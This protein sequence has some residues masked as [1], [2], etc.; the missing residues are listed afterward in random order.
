MKRCH[1]D[2]VRVPGTQAWEVLRRACRAGREHSRV[3]APAGG[4][5]RGGRDVSLGGLFG[6]SWAGGQEL[7]TEVWG[8]TGVGARAE[9]R[10]SAYALGTLG[11]D[12]M[13]QCCVTVI[14]LA[15][16]GDGLQRFWTV[17]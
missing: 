14:G 17:D 10:R 13:H 3:G 9:C 16:V 7:R 15:W 4:H 8:D 6:E 11:G 1:F 12:D 5:P 2:R